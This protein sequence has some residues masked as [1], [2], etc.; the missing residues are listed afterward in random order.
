MIDATTFRNN[1]EAMATPFVLPNAEELRKMTDEVNENKRKQFI[2]DLKRKVIEE[3]KAGGSSLFINNFSGDVE[4][5]KSIFE[6]LGY[7]VIF[8]Q[9]L[10]DNDCIFIRW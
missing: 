9:D 6:P 5:I 7:E 1:L 10:Y 2:E 4:E 3:A 8:E